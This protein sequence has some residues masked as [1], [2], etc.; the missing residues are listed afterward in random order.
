MQEGQ[1]VGSKSATRPTN[2]KLQAAPGSIL[3]P[4]ISI[5]VTIGHFYFGLTL[6]K[7][8]IAFSL[9]MI[10]NLQPKGNLI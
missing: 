5:L 1:C 7:L 10:Y 6:I 8:L 9:L 4:D 2:Y 3:K